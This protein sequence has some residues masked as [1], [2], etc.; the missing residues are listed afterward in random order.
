VFVK[1]VAATFLLIWSGCARPLADP[2]PQPQPGLEVGVD[3]H[4]HFTMSQAGK[5]IFKGEPGSADLAMRGSTQ[6]INQIDE[7][8]LQRSGVRL[9]LGT[10]WPPFDVRPG[11]TALDEAIHQLHAQQEF[12]LR[13]PGFAVV[14]SAAE[15]R[16]ALAH[17]RI[18]IVPAVEGGEGITS[19]EDVDRLWAAG[20]RS[21]A[22]VHFSTS[23][24]GGAAKGQL[25][26]NLLN[27]KV[28]GFEPVGLTAVGRAAV[29]RMIALGILIDL[30]HASDAL[31]SAVLELTAARGV[32]VV[33]SHSGA[34][35]LTPMERNITDA[36]ALRI[37][38]QGGQLGVTVFD[39]M[40][41]DVPESER[42]PGFVPHS[43]DEVVAHWLHL[44]K[45]TGPEALTLGSDLN[46]LVTRH[47]PGGSCPHGIRN[48]GDFAELFAALQA[49]GIPRA[50][51][52]GMGERFLHLLEQV[53]A[54][55]D[56]S[57]RAV[58]KRA[59][60]IDTPLFDT[61]L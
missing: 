34:R 25:A 4:L 42:W 36:S 13:R 45:V 61:P 12:S 31:T 18:A 33:N 8:G 57:A 27:L 26:R 50:A 41:A 46:G 58:A 53:E 16:V 30:A 5:P 54:K 59:R 43:C 48:S 6:L 51:L 44:A 35:A 22:L 39:K 37:V 52:D 24:I 15:A 14:H 19:A 7:A 32:P 40:V 23:A 38:A 9:T 28:E 3:L 17:G 56:P 21:I 11:R 29:E 49:H 47:P 20:A 55:A 10:V 60:R 1:P 2:M